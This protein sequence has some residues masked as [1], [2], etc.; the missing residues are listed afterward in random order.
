V[1]KPP[2]FS[3]AMDFTSSIAVPSSSFLRRHEYA[4]LSR[5]D[6][7][8]S[9]CFLLDCGEF[10]FDLDSDAKLVCQLL[11]ALE[12]ILHLD[13]KL[14]EHHYF[15]KNYLHGINLSRAEEDSCVWNKFLATGL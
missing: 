5:A 4:R 3:S 10:S 6:S 15:I 11:L 1:D 7:P 13:E 12:F 2:H 14:P 9:R 8:L